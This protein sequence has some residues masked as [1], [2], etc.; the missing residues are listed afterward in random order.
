MP[1]S[2]THARVLR[3]FRGAQYDITID[4]SAGRCSGTTSISIDGMKIDEK[5]LPMFDTGLH[6]VEVV[7]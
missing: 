5:I 6:A 7:I 2:M 4:N 3:T 1:K